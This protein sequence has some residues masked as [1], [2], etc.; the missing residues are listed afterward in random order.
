VPRDSI[1]SLTLSAKKHLMRET[2]HLAVSEP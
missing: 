2:K 1:T